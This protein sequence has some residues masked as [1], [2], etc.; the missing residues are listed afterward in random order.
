MKELTRKIKDKVTIQK[1]TE[2][3]TTITIQKTIVP[4]EN[5]TLYE[6][7]TLTGG[8]SEAEYNLN[9]DYKLRWNWKKS[10]GFVGYKALIVK[11]NCEYVSALN[12]KTA[13][14]KYRKGLDGGKV[15]IDECLNL[16]K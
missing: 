1:E 7:N 15:Y 5:H 13:L 12:K 11:N 10:D 3:K 14:I 4:H 6:I 9:K 8:I 2:K 16:A